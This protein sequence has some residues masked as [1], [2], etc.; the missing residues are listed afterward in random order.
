MSPSLVLNVAVYF[1]AASM[2][3]GGAFANFEVRGEVP[4]AAGHGVSPLMD[5]PSGT[6]DRTTGATGV[7]EPATVVGVPAAVVGVTAVVVE[8]VATFC[9]PSPPVSETATA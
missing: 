9:L 4:S 5:A 2:H 6:G 7:G 8:A 1:L 3:V